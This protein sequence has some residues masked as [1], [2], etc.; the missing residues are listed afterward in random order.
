MDTYSYLIC[1]TAWP[2]TGSLM[3]RLDDGKNTK[4]GKTRK[5]VS[6]SRLIKEDRQKNL[7]LFKEWVGKWIL[8]R[9]PEIT[10]EEMNSIKVRY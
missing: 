7:K 9:W 10:K 5:Y 8:K 4:D 3:R 2:D 1:Y 6:I